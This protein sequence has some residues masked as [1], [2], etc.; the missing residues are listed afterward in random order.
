MRETELWARMTRHLGA[1]YVRVWAEQIGLAELKGSTVQEAMA[2]GVPCKT[3][4]RAVWV[5]L[6]LPATER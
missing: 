2:A 3:I 5:A 4:W 1:G 6:E